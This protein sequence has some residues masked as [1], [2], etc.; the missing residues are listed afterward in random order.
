MN[1]ILGV[2][3]V[4][5]GLGLHFFGFF[6]LSYSMWKREFLDADASKEN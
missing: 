5:C 2:L 1:L 6:D 3:R 4:L